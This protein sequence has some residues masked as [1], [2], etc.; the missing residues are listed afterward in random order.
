MEIVEQ[1]QITA[2]A[3]SAARLLPPVALAADQAL[4]PADVEQHRRVESDARA[5]FEADHCVTVMIRLVTEYGRAAMV[6]EAA[7]QS[8]ALGISPLEWLQQRR[9]ALRAELDATR[10]EA[11]RAMS[12]RKSLSARAGPLQLAV[13]KL[14]TSHLQEQAHIH[15]ALEAAKRGSKQAT[16]YTRLAEAGLTHE[17]IASLGM[18]DPTTDGERALERMHARLPI[19]TAQL[20]AIAD[21]RRSADYAHLAGLGFDALVAAVRATH[22]EPV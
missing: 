13:S 19:I 20:R 10:A 9:S 6:S 16:L 2:T 1:K 14:E 5:R 7:V 15:Q 17:Q 4:S 8:E 22:D 21:Y 12:R 18:T 11:S 3:A